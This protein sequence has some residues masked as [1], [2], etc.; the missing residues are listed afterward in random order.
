ME[1][2]LTMTIIYECR[3]VNEKTDSNFNQPP[4]SRL[5]ISNFQ[6]NNKVLL[7]QFQFESHKTISNENEVNS[8]DKYLSIDIWLQIYEKFRKPLET[9]IAHPDNPPK[10]ETIVMKRAQLELR[11]TWKKTRSFHTEI[12]RQEKKNVDNWPSFLSIKVRMISALDTYKKML[13]KRTSGESLASLDLSAEAN[14]LKADPLTDNVEEYV[15]SS[16]TAIKPLIYNPSSNGSGTSANAA[17][18]EYTPSVP[19][20]EEVVSYTPTRIDGMSKTGKANNPEKTDLNRNVYIGKKKRTE[21]CKINDLFGGDSDDMFENDS[22]S[23]SNLHS[24]VVGSELFGDDSGELH[25]SVGT[26]HRN[27]RSATK[28][29]KRAQGNLDGWVTAR[30][31]KDIQSDM[32]S[33]A[34][35][36]TKKKRKIAMSTPAKEP[37]DKLKKLDEEAK[38][39]KALREEWEKREKKTVIDRIRYDW[40]TMV[41]EIS[42]L[43]CSFHL[44]EF[45][46]FVS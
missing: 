5:F 21:D 26:S 22:P 31:P 25:K 13:S 24:V 1:V 6:V 16:R 41:I 44:Q 32:K 8:L 15:P 27:L 35:D 9:Y 38:K 23:Q 46:R 12:I 10:D 29:S 33:T 36:E 7:F 11:L 39:L 2:C 17:S 34:F 19:S 45:E 18:D 3:E 28:S 14:H 43:F 37:G 30:R 4:L 40:I 20:S 42:Y